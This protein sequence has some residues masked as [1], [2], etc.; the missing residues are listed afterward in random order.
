MIDFQKTPDLT[1]AIIHTI[2]LALTNPT[3]NPTTDSAAID[4]VL[5]LII[6]HGKRI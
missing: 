5:K 1:F 6:Q 4:V 2:S 3:Y